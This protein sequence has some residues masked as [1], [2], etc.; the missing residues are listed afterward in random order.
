MFDM[1]TATVGTVERGDFRHLCY[2]ALRALVY[3][4]HNTAT[5][6][7]LDVDTAPAEENGL[8]NDACKVLLTIAYA[9][10]YE[11]HPSLV[12]QILQRVGGHEIADSEEDPHHGLTWSNALEYVCTR[13]PRHFPYTEN[14]NG[15][16]SYEFTKLLSLILDQYVQNCHPGYGFQYSMVNEKQSKMPLQLSGVKGVHFLT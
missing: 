5:A 16:S 13:L 3:P 7:A 8:S 2:A 15:L 11:E 10:M 12:R 1:A 4:W 14:M 6:R 9:F